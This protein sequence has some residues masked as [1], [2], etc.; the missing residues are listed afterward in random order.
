MSKKNKLSNEQCPNKKKIGDYCKKHVNTS[1][2]NRIDAA[3]SGSIFI[4]IKKRLSPE[5]SMYTKDEFLSTPADKV[6]YS[7]LVNTLRYYKIQIHGVKNELIISL[8]KFFNDKYISS[9]IPKYLAELSGP[10]VYDRK[11]CDNTTDFYDLI[12]VEDISNVYFFS[13]TEANKIYACDIRS[14]HGLVKTARSSVN[15]R[16]MHNPDIVHYKILNPYT[17]EEIDDTHIQRYEEKIIILQ[18]NHIAIEYDIETQID[19]KTKFNLECLEI[20]QIIYGYGYAV[21]H[22]WF[23]KLSFNQLK[24]FYFKLQDIWDYRL[25]L[26]QDQKAQIVP[27]NSIFSFTEKHMMNSVYYTESNFNEIRSIILGIIRKLVTKGVTKSDCINGAIYVLTA[28]VEI[29][30]DAGEAL[31]GFVFVSGVNDV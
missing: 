3:K 22:E 29:S 30:S 6:N 1:S 19:N 16:D 23:L 20:F 13:Y 4:K 2:S 7:R 26:T 14:F 21:N 27:D 31:P 12:P 17:R 18:Q 25:Q 8:A 28:L 10:G 9:D 11:L 24:Q 15:N 5:K